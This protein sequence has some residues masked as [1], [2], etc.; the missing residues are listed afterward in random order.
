VEG[1]ARLPVRRRQASTPLF[2]REGALLPMLAGIPKDNRKDL[3]DVEL[4]ICLSKGFRGKAEARYACDDGESFGYL[5][6]RRSVYDLEA[7]LRGDGLHLRILAV[8][9]GFGKVRFTPVTLERFASVRL[10]N[11]DGS[12]ILLDPEPF[13]SDIWGATA[14]FYAWRRP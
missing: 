7:S 4:F 10:E 5:R 8:Q 12:A 1:P 11:G 3:K 2:V 9:E 13:T 14:T 6:G